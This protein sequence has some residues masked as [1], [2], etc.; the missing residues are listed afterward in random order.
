MEINNKEFAQLIVNKIGGDADYLT[1]V[2]NL[3]SVVSIE[4]LSKGNTIEMLRFVSLKT[5][6]KNVPKLF[7]PSNLDDVNEYQKVWKV[8][9]RVSKLLTAKV[10][11]NLEYQ[12][13]QSPENVNQ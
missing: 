6:K 5:V 9:G 13:M 3:L 2:L 1:T 7:D 4:E 10:R 8:R 11:E 12:E